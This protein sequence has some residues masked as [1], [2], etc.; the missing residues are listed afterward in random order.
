MPIVHRATPVRR[1]YAEPP[2]QAAEPL[3]RVLEAVI[4][5]LLI[6]I[7]L[8]DVFES[9][10]LPRPTPSRLRP[11]AMLV[12]GGWPLWRAFGEVAKT[13][14]RRERRLGIFAPLV[15]L[16]LL[17]LWIVM[18]IVGYGLLFDVLAGQLEPSPPDLLTA[19]YFAAVSLLTIGYGDIVATSGAGRIVA[20]GAGGSGLAI[21]AVAAAYLFSLYASFQRREVLV[22]TL[23]ARAGA[24]PS[25]VTLLES[26]VKFGPD[27]ELA[28]IFSAWEHWS[29]EV[30]ESHLAYPILVFFR[31]THDQESWV[32]A[33]G[34]L[35]D[36]ATLV[37]TTVEDG[38]TGQAKVMR[39]IGAHLIEDI[40]YFFRFSYPQD[41]GVERAEFDQARRQLEAAGYRITLDADAAWEK[42]ANLRSDYAGRLNVLA[43]YLSVPPAQWIGDRTLMLHPPGR[44]RFGRS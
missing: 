43:R 10:I 36:A 41:P 35:L 21:V 20:I 29:A 38:P 5:L 25:G 2:M 17:G 15:V 3:L 44:A 33:L 14:D 24:P 40:A 16:V 7:V 1:R 23:D 39:A 30:L 18:L 9:I 12:R 11:A 31:S 42:F 13:V 22:V 34:A 6:A 37:L 19:M 28:R 8:Y 32:A 4:G 26:C 27:R